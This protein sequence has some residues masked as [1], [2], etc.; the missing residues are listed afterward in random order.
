MDGD[1]NHDGTS[2]G[3]LQRAGTVAGR[4]PGRRRLGRRRAESHG[5]AAIHAVLPAHLGVHARRGRRRN[6]EQVLAA[7]VDTVFLVTGLDGDFNLRR[8]ERYLAAAYGTGAQPVVLLNKADLCD[9][10]AG[11]VAEMEGI[12][13]GVPVHAL[14]ATEGAGLEAL[15]PYL[16]IGRTVALLGS[17]GVGKST[18]IN[19]LLGDD[20]LA[21]AAVRASDSHGRHTT[22]HRELIRLPRRR[23]RHRHAG[24][25]RAA[26][27]G[28]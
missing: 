15:A 9:D 26:A 25:A 20:R 5:D 3:T 21:V 14:S 27:L 6:T 24:H 1:G 19:A 10:P 23:P 2:D 11:A 28:R 18:L 13:P 16:G 12:A 4:L 7:N 17:S 8:I 22:T